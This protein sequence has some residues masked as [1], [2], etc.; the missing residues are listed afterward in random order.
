MSQQLTKFID[1]RRLDFINAVWT[2]WHLVKKRAGFK[3]SEKQALH[4]EFFD[5]LRSVDARVI[6]ND[7]VALTVQL[8]DSYNR[9]VISLR[10]GPDSSDISV[11]KQIICWEEYAAVV[12]TYK[13]YFGGEKPVTIID[14]G[15]NIGL[16][17]IY[18]AAHFNICRIVSVEPD[19][20]NFRALSANVYGLSV[21]PVQGAVWNADSRLVIVRDFR[22]KL[23]WSSRVVEVSESECDFTAAYTILGL[24]EKYNLKS[25]DILKVDIEGAEKEVFAENSCSFLSSTKCVAIEI[26]DEFG[27]REDIYTCLQKYNFKYFTSGELTI[28]I[29]MNLATE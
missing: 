13:R 15:G 22:D 21:Q 9:R 24:I 6:K 17:S 8:G 14:A 20:E 4:L 11:F 28:G 5:C 16:T 3:L 7:G 18:L 1:V 27:C 19:T 25:V 26:H 12:E 23:S 2:I 29:N 10:S